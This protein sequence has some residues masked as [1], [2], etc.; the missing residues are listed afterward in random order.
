MGITALLS[1]L[2]E[3]ASTVVGTEPAVIPRAVFGRRKE[4]SF[5]AAK[6]PHGGQKLPPPF[7]PP[8]PNL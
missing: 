4:L 5:T 6:T 1:Q 2:A 7:W 3:I 8:M